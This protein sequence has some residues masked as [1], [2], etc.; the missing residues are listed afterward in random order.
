MDSSGRPM[1]QNNIAPASGA[2]DVDA[3]KPA[4]SMNNNN[5]S[6]ATFPASLA[7]TPL[8]L[9]QARPLLDQCDWVDK[10]I[11]AARQIMGGQAVNGFLRATATMQRMKKQRQR[12]INKTSGGADGAKDA[13]ADGIKKRELD[14][15]QEGLQEMT[16]DQDAE[17]ALKLDVMNTRTAKKFKSE[18]EMGEEFCIFLHELLRQLIVEMDPSFSPPDPLTHKG[19]PSVLLQARERQKQGLPMVVAEPTAFPTMNTG[20]QMA[21]ANSMLAAS[22]LTNVTA[23]V[24]Q[25][26][27]QSAAN[28]GLASESTLRKSRKKKLPPS[29][30][31][32]VSIAEFDP[33]GKRLFSK[34]EHAFRVAEVLR[35]RTLRKGDFVAARL[36]SRDLWI[37]ARVQ[38]D[39]ATHKL[40]PGELLHLSEAR[41]SQLFREKVILQDVEDAGSNHAVARDLVLPLPRSFS[42]AAEWCAR[43]KK[44]Y[45]VYAMYPQTTS[46][47]SAT[48]ID[49]TMYARGDDDIVVVEFDGDEPDAIT[50]TIPKCHIP[51]RFVILIP[52]HFAAANPQPTGAVAAGGTSK[53]GKKTVSRGVF[54]NGVDDIEQAANLALNGDLTFDFED[55]L[56]GL[57]FNDMDFAM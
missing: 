45:R 21:L 40:S 38:Q 1:Q 57:D 35:F 25:K 33:S 56:P 27:D 4:S 3:T 32:P 28:S 34:K 19:I 31:P 9:E 11:W 52:R 5:K 46:L 30:E 54:G 53:A 41:R 37:L 8:T 7:A 49:S 22:K 39:F 44:G 23:H 47:Y 16:T 18:C 55:D 6:R 15:S 12:Q 10:S 42:E 50:G 51:A 36:S 2:D 29:N 14:A 43:L 20:I 17:E 24:P 13:T 26:S 48:V